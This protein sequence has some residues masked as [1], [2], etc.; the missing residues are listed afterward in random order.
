MTHAPAQAIARQIERDGLGFPI[1]VD[2]DLVL[3]RILG[4]YDKTGL[5]HVTRR[6]LGVPI[7]VPVGFRRM[8]RPA[9]TLIDESG[10]IRWLDMTDDYRLRGDEDTIRDGVRTAF[11][12][13]RE[14]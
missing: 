8:P 7:G 2:Q 3:T 6:V 12:L 9:T 10:I 11:G 4:W 5:K 13:G 14:D 1:I